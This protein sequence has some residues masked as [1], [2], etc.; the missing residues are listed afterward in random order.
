MSEHWNVKSTITGKRQI[1]I[2]IRVY[3]QLDLNVGEQIQFT[4]DGNNIIVSA[5][6]ET[7]KC[8]A[9]KGKG[10]LSNKKCFVCDGEGILKKEYT[11]NIY[12]L[13]GIIMKNAKKHNVALKVSANNNVIPRLELLADDYNINDN[14]FIKD[15]L[16][17][18]I[19]LDYLNEFG[20]SDSINEDTIISTLITEKAQEDMNEILNGYKKE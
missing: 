6:K 20:L 15:K 17:T 11:E 16:Q 1:T 13:L 12:M 2:P 10:T 9:C 5:D 3:K 19:I 7:E 4:Y 14:L 18:M 8:F